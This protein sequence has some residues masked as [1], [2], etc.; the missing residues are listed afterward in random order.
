MDSAQ[1]GLRATGF[2]PA[3]DSGSGGTVPM[4]FNNNIL[5][6]DV[7]DTLIAEGPARKVGRFQ[8]S[9][10]ENEKPGRRQI[11]GFGTT[12]TGVEAKSTLANRRRS[13]LRE[14][15]A[16]SGPRPLDQSTSKR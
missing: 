3:E 6:E 4:T 15:K 9:T 2:T 10:A 8:K 14:H 1:I 16:P 12:K 11:G 13:T 7:A 5:W